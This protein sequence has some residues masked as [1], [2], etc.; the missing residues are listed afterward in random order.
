MVRLRFAT[1][2]G[3]ALLAVLAL[4]LAACGDSAGDT[5][6]TTAAAQTTTTTTAETTTTAAATTTTTAATTTTTEAPATTAREI[7]QV[8]II[9]PGLPG[10]GAGGFYEAARP[11]IASEYGLE[12]E[13]IGAGQGVFNTI[14]QVASGQAPFSLSST[15]NVLQAR[16]EGVPIVQIWAGYDY[17][18]CIMSHASQGIED[19][20]DLEGRTVAVTLGTA[21]WEFIKGEYGLENVNEVAYSGS[22][23]PFAADETLSQQCFTINEP[24]VAEQEGIDY[25]LL[26]VRDS[27][28]NP[29]SNLLFTTE[30]IIATDPDL[31]R[32][33]VHAVQE[34]WESYL[35]DPVATNEEMIALGSTQ[36]MDHLAFAA[37][38]LRD[39]LFTG[40]LGFSEPARIET[41]YQQMLDSGALTTEID[42]E[43]AYTN[44][45]LP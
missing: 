32:D 9:L 29:Y 4:V 3:V 10:A 1:R 13:L 2:T 37:E 28:F 38:F 8:T 21:Y 39:N 31:V 14:P 12:I 22:I 34:G 36:D 30:D 19:F 27:G 45:F 17:P 20:S 7:R 40:D 33:V 44:E 42:W 35:A 6:T 24:Y 26:L 25:S 16:A 11:E 41:T 15:A 18:V 5:T 43:T 23:G